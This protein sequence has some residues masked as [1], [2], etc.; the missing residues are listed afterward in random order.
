[1][2]GSN[3]GHQAYWSGWRRNVSEDK[4]SRYDSGWLTIHQRW[5]AFMRRQKHSSL[6]HGVIPLK[7]LYVFVDEHRR[8]E[9]ALRIERTTLGRTYCARCDE[10]TS[11]VTESKGFYLWGAFVGN[12]R[13]WH[14]IYLGK[15]GFGPT[16]SLK[17]RICEELKDERAFVWRAVLGK[18]RPRF[19]RQ[20]KGSRTA[21]NVCLHAGGNP[22]HS[23]PAP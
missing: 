23:G 2:C 21:G 16:W 5:E 19:R 3:G 22:D 12:K 6:N 20:S 11:G 1:M 14:S 15:A 10:M 8:N 7:Q 13:Y 17:K 4:F 18:P 9:G